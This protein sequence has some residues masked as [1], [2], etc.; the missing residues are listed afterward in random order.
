M[1][2]VNAFLQ[3]VVTGANDTKFYNPPDGDWPAQVS[4]LEGKTIKYKTKEGVE[5][6]QPVMT[7]V[8][9]LLSDECRRAVHAEKAFARQTIFLDFLDNAALDM[10]EGKNKALGYVREALG[11]NEKG[12]QW[13]PSDLIGGMA[14]VTTKTEAAKDKE[15]GHAKTNPDG[16]IMMNTNVV[17][18]VVIGGARRAA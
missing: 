10:G 3:T 17:K 1:F 6:E 13:K 8:W 11:Q 15:T 12:K 18:V 5:V 16:S 4:K 9:E 2:D 7:V 14:Q